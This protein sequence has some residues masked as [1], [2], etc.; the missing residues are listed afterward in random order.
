MSY[1]ISVL[2]VLALVGPCA[3]SLKHHCGVWYAAAALAVAA[4]FSA[5][6]V[7]ATQGA[8][9]A[10]VSP[11]RSGALS[12]VLFAVVMFTGAFRP[13]SAARVRLMQVRRPLAVL[14]CIVACGHIACMAPFEAAALGSGAAATGAGLFQIVAMAFLALSLALLGAT[15]FERV[16]E[17]MRQQSWQRLHLLAYPFFAA[18]IAHAALFAGTRSAA[19]CAAFVVCGLAYAA[20]RVR[21]F[22]KDRALRRR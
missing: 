19:A 12:C 3:R 8:A 9:E 7:G 15:S 21:R 16:A 5:T 4:A 10:F 22:R 1:V 11:V 6:L 17:R 20:V 2:C 18:L 14:A 13:G